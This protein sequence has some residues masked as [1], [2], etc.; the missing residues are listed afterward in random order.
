MGIGACTLPHTAINTQQHSSSAH[1]KMPASCAA[2]QA[3]KS[4]RLFNHVQVPKNTRTCMSTVGSQLCSCSTKSI[5][6]EHLL[7]T[8][9]LPQEGRL[10]TQATVP[11]PLHPLVPPQEV[12]EMVLTSERARLALQCTAGRKRPCSQK[13]AHARRQD[14][15]GAAWD[16]WPPHRMRTRNSHSWQP[17]TTTGGLSRLKTR[18]ALQTLTTRARTRALALQQFQL[19]SKLPKQLPEELSLHSPYTRSW[20]SSNDAQAQGPRSDRPRRNRVPSE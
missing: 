3:I 13:S 12:G 5:G 10:E 19:Q 20:L 18:T 4:G 1:A 8:A 11:P 15:K 17:Q 2:M 9:V 14:K 16:L 6:S 7:T